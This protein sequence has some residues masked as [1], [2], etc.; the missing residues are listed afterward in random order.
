MHSSDF[1]N[2]LIT[3]FDKGG[4]LAC[5][6]GWILSA[7]YGK[8]VSVITFSSSVIGNKPFYDD[9]VSNIDEYKMI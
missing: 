1:E 9:I 3:G 4:A 8:K 2:I 7:A 5:I 6:C